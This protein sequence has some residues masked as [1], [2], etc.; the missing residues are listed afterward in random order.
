MPL[1]IGVVTPG[2]MLNPLNVKEMETVV[3]YPKQKQQ[4]LRTKL[5]NA[6]E[7]KTGLNS[8]GARVAVIDGEAMA[9]SEKAMEILTNEPLKTAVDKL[10]YF[11]F[12]VNDQWIPVIAVAGGPLQN[13][14]KY[15][16]GDL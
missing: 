5:Q 12:K 7:F 14:T 6:K 3:N 16:L 11:E 4:S 13:E 8:K 1:A 9:V 10:Q 15:N 2:S